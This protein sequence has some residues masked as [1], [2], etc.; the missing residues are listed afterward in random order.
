MGAI[1][2]LGKYTDGKM[3]M[4]ILFKWFEIFSFRKTYSLRSNEIF[5]ISKTCQNK[6]GAQS[7]L[8]SLIVGGRI[9]RGGW[10][11]RKKII[12]CGGVIIKCYRGDFYKFR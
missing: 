10:V 2:D 5:H 11:V 4:V 9:S 7:T 8:L 3:Q 6:P 12:K 1:Y